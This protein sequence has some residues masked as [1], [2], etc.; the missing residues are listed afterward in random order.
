MLKRSEP[1]YTQAEQDLI[2]KAN[3]LL[4]SSGKPPLTLDQEAALIRKQQDKDRKATYIPP[5]PAT[6]DGLAMAGLAMLAIPAYLL[7]RVIRKA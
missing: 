7:Y 1:H 5:P 2:A 6:F 3:Y 4:V